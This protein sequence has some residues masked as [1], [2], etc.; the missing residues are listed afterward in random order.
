[1]CT[2]CTSILCGCH[3]SVSYCTQ[4]QYGTNEVGWLVQTIWEPQ[5]DLMF[6]KIKIV[7]IRKCSK[8]LCQVFRCNAYDYNSDCTPDQIVFPKMHS[9]CIIKSQMCSQSA[10]SLL[11]CLSCLTATSRVL[12]QCFV[13]LSKTGTCSPKTHFQRSHTQQ[14]DPLHSWLKPSNGSAASVVILQ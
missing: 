5:I 10:Y 12:P 1:M 6:I 8:N 14:M 4:F 3:T 11:H 7:K 13:Q 9:R 2:L